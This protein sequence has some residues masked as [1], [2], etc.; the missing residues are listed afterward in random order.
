[1][2]IVG[3]KVAAFFTKWS[4]S[5]ATPP[6]HPQLNQFC[7]MSNNTARWPPSDYSMASQITFGS[8]PPWP[9]GSQDSPN[10]GATGTPTASTA[11]NHTSLVGSTSLSNQIFPQGPDT[12][13]PAGQTAELFRRVL[14]TPSTTS[15]SVPSNPVPTTSVNVQN[16]RS[17][18]PEVDLTRFQGRQKQ[19]KLSSET[20]EQVNQQSLDQLRRT[21]A[22]DPEYLRLTVSD[23]LQLDAAYRAYQSAVHRIAIENK[24]H[25]KP[26]LDYLGNEAR[27]RGPSCYN[28]F[29]K[30][31]PVAG[32]INRDSKWS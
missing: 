11:T 23:K 22:K 6:S 5:P 32:A 7:P 3:K 15:L 18:T 9:L 17:P 31:D 26:V 21:V 29:C 19:S 8:L 27:I 2:T 4:S 12:S 30:Y 10:P 20:M 25:I 28:N 24:L 16:H 1:M 13:T 14:T